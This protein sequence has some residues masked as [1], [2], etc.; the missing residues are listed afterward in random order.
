[1]LA[2]LAD[3]SVVSW[4]F[5]KEKKEEEE[6]LK[7]RKMSTLGATPVELVPFLHQGIPAIC[8]VGARATIFSGSQG[9]IAS[10][11]VLVNVSGSNES[12]FR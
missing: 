6:R 7:D 11:P 12:S 2:G 1:M 4:V 5:D 3:G 8:A 9:R 10:A